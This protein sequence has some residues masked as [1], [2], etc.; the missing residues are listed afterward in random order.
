MITSD[1]NNVHRFKIYFENSTR[2][3]NNKG[4]KSSFN[5]I[6]NYRTWYAWEQRKLG[7]NNIYFKFNSKTVLT[8]INP[9]KSI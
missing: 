8:Y 5:I 6:L 9:Y 3:N 7:Q 4:I 2:I 1:F